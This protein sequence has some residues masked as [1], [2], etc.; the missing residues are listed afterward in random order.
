MAK[1]SLYIDTRGRTVLHRS[2]FSWLAALASPLFAL[3][4]RLW[5]TLLASLPA[6]MALHSVINLSIEQLPGE[7][8][9]GLA[10]LGWLLGW[11]W[12]CGRWANDW[13]RRLLRRAG[14]TMTATELPPAAAGPAA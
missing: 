12:A 2:G 6:T 13:H 7:V 11:S 1:L 9:Q 4:R 5:W 8:A 14:Y 10:A 3:H